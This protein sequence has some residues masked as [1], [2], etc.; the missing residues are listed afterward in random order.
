[1][2]MYT[3]EVAQNTKDPKI[4]TDILRK[5]NDDLVSCYAAENPNTPPEILVD[6]LRKG[7]N[8]WVSGNAARNPNTP[9]EILAEVLKRG[10]NNNISYYAALNP[11]T[12]PEALAEVL[13]RGNDDYVSCYAAENPNCPLKEKILWMR[14]TG[15]IGVED[16]NK[17]IIE[18]EEEK[19]DEDLEKLRNIYKRLIKEE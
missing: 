15:K 7:K 2:N 13:R 5:G 3:V 14:A 18:Y 6:I 19:K 16:P 17:H 9:P 11:N 4:L 8:D 10:K 1:M 12:P